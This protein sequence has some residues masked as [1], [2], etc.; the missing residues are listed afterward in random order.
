MIRAELKVVGGKHHGRTI[1]LPADRFLIGREK[2]CHLRPNT[3]SVSRYHCALTADE[4]S[5]QVR[6]L[7][8]TNGTFVN[9]E[10][11][12]GLVPLKS[13]DRL[14]AGHLEF[15]IVVHESAPAPPAP[16]ETVTAATAGGVVSSSPPGPAEPPVTETMIDVPVPLPPAAMDTETSVLEGDTTIVPPVPSP[17]EQPSP[18]PQP[19]VQQPMMAGQPI[20]QQPIPQQPMD[21]QQLLQQ[22]L[23]QQ[24]LQQQLLQQQAGALPPQPAAQAAKTQMLPVRLPDPETTGVREPEPEPEP[25]PENSEKPKEGDESTGDESAGNKA[26]DEMPSTTAADII[27]QYTHRRK[28]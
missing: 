12:S 14:S 23:F 18:Y 25:E 24:F 13:G 22:Q 20:L 7:G 5:I 2:D 9:G 6:D 21:Q 16:V 26:A 10:R 8:S 28:P 15:E 4:H 11:V 3:E 27:R 17:Q 19:A 1:P